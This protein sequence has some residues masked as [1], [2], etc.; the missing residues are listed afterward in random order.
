MV[1]VNII[2]D[3]ADGGWIYS[4]FIAQFKKYSK[5]IIAVNETKPEKYNVSHCLP[6]YTFPG[7]IK[8]K[9]STSWQSHQEKSGALHNKFI[10]VAKE[11]D[12]AISHSQKY[13]TML[14]DNHNLSSV[15]SVIPGVDLDK[16]K[17]RGTRRSNN[18]DK[19]IVGYIGR[20]Y[21]SSDRKNPK[22]L[23][24]ISKLPY[25]EFRTTSGNVSQGKIPKFYAGLDLVISP[26]SIEGGPMAIQESL[27]IGVPILCMENV[28]VSNEFGLGVIKALNNDDFIEKLCL[29]YS[30]KTHI[31][32]WRSQ[33][34]MNRMRSQVESQTWEKFV[35]EHD[36]IW[37]MITNKSWKNSN[38]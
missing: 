37:D 14:R 36:K 34:I 23:D 13:A 15:I 24:R 18:S 11:V 31:K 10:A 22:L 7:K 30:D 29:V 28:G 32:Y 8:N 33:N 25:V 20:Q 27:A 26:A 17:Q 6:Y 1:V 9:P 21:T 35:S 4:Q 38:I 5:H 16:F 12:V 19:I 3:E 2:C